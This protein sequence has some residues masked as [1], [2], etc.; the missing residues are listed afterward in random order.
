MNYVFVY[1]NILAQVQIEI[2]VILY[3]KTFY[4]RDINPCIHVWML[5]IEREIIHIKR[6]PPPN[7]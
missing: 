1:A 5:K 3:Q 4:D 6:D 7:L 2:S